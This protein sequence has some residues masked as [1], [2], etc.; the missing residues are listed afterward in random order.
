MPELLIYAQLAGHV[1]KRTE[2]NRIPVPSGWRELQWNADD[3]ITGFSAGAY[4]NGNEVIIAF[5]GTN[6][7][8]WKDFVIANIPAGF[9]QG[10]LQITQAVAFVMKVIHDN[11]GT[12]VTLTGHSLGGGLA[13]LMAVFFDLKATIFDPAPFAFSARNP[14]VLAGLG[15]S[16][17]VSGARHSAF[18]NYLKSAGLLFAAR[19]KNVTSYS[20]SGEVLEAI[21]FK[22]ATISGSATKIALGN[23][24]VLDGHHLT[25]LLSGKVTLH[26]MTLLNAVLLS[27]TFAAGVTQ[28]SHAIEVFFDESLYATKPESAVVPD[29]VTRLLKAQLM[30]SS[31][32]S[33]GFLDALGDDLRRIGVAGTAAIK[34][35]NVGILALV[36]EYYRYLAKIDQK[37]FVERVDGGIQLDLSRIDGASDGKGREVFLRHIRQ[38]LDQQSPVRTVVGQFQRVTLHASDTGLHATSSDDG[39]SDLIIGGS[40][41]DQIS[42]GDANDT[43]FGLDGADVLVGG[44]GDDVLYGGNGNDLYRFS[45]DDGND[46]IDDADGLG[47]IALDGKPLSGGAK[48]KDGFW[49]SNDR[50]IS[51]TRIAND[52]GGHDLIIARGRS[53]TMR[54]RGWLPAQLG[55]TLDAAPLDPLPSSFQGAGAIARSV[56]RVNLSQAQDDSHTTPHRA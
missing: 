49:L 31:A 56:D 22:F 37:G 41:P 38:W 34:E 13:S 52:R 28:Q 18:S 4:R 53:N 33:N 32:P 19:E 24:S 20:I 25:N 45:S 14:L 27:P 42:G 3:S 15:A 16:Y 47:S 1:Y 30:D 40:H 50:E 11:P 26:S 12:H 51:Y 35:V 36:A 10:S 55:I 23:P 9:G 8:L 6:E 29:L 46:V 5:T 54:I 2:E 21:R 17:L 43:L 39:Q 48:E 7:S 44:K